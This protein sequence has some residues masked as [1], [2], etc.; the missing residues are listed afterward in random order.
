MTSPNGRQD[1][2]LQSGQ[3]LHHQVVRI[4]KRMAHTGAYANEE[5]QMAARVPNNYRYVVLWTCLT[6][7]E[8]VDL[9]TLISKAEFA[10]RE[11]GF[12]ATNKRLTCRKPC[13]SIHTAWLNTVEGT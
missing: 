3:E 8:F 7:A 2:D 9:A 10:D 4:N 11:I 6:V 13:R 12:A 5:A 1:V